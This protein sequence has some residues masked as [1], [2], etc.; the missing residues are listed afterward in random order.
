VSIEVRYEEASVISDPAIRSGKAYETPIYIG[1]LVG[2][3]LRLGAQGRA[4]RGEG[5][6]K[7]I[8]IRP[9]HSRG[10]FISITIFLADIAT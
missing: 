5:N 7:S 8:Y 4:R 6:C 10:R 9:R 1:L 2:G 3:P